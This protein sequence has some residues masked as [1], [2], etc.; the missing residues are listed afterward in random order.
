MLPVLLVEPDPDRAGAMRAMLDATTL[1]EQVLFVRSADDARAA[2]S[3]PRPT[4]VAA[5]VGELADE[6]RWPLVRELGHRGIGVVLVQWD[7][8]PTIDWRSRGARDLVHANELWRLAPAIHRGIDAPLEDL[9]TSPPSYYRALERLVDLTARLN[10]AP[11]LDAVADMVDD[12]CRELLHCGGGA[13]LTVQHGEVVLPERLATAYGIPVR[14][15]ARATLVGPAIEARAPRVVP[16]TKALGDSPSVPESVRAI[17]VFPVWTDHPV[18]ALVAHWPEPHTPT[19]EELAIGGSMASAIASA[20]DNLMLRSELESRVAH[21][22]AQ[23]DEANHAL[24]AFNIAIAHDLRSPTMAVTGFAQLVLERDDLAAE[25]R[26]QIGRI[27]RAGAQMADRIEALHA[28]AR[29]VPMQIEH[30][31]CDLTEVARGVAADLVDQEP[32]RR[33]EV[34][35]Q[36]GMR[37]PLDPRMARTMLENLLR[38]AFKFTR[39]RPDPRI[40]V[41]H[42]ARTGAFYVRDNGV[43]FDMRRAHGLFRPF[44]RLHSDERFEGT[45]I[46]LSIVHRVVG[47][48]GGRVWAEAAPNEGACFYFTIPEDR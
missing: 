8:G 42:E 39:E 31:Q 33:I 30:T 22:T 3:A 27:F 21:R 34:H 5:V 2:L 47:R 41:G 37:A 10:D 14:R 23:L 28:V 12:A 40:E 9:A 25:V 11:D 20:S 26:H 36:E 24:E 29:A 44:R 48:H 45:G 13:L 18:G 7:A 46:G 35:V 19:H 16:D 15:D 6:E 43:G 38:N 32:N 1:G 17:C 4:P